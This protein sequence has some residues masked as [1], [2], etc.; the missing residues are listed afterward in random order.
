[1]KIYSANLMDEETDT[2]YS[3]RYLATP[4]EITEWIAA[5]I[6]P[7]SVA[8]VVVITDAAQT[9]LANIEAQSYLLAG[10]LLM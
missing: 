7:S 9:A 3:I 2:L 5:G 10:H 8:E 6:V 1:M 4:D